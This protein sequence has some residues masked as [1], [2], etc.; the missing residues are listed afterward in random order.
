MKESLQ[1]KRDAAKDPNLLLTLGEAANERH[2]RVERMTPFS[3]LSLTMRL[4]KILNPVLVNSQHLLGQLQDETQAIGAMS[5]IFADLDPDEVLPLAYEL[6][7]KYLYVGNGRSMQKI[8]GDKARNEW[9]SD[10]P[11]DII[12]VIVHLVKVNCSDFFTTSL[13]T[14]I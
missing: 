14:L 1:K 4:N 12:P 5:S 7:D 8:P 2:Y 9:F 11:E 10:K 13:S 3:A 6:M